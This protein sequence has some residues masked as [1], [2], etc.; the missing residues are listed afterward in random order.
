[1]GLVRSGEDRGKRRETSRRRRKNNKRKE[2]CHEKR[3]TMRT[4]PGETASI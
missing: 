4:W 1:M 2:S 3:L